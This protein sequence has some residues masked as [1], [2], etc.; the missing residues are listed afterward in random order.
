MTQWVMSEAL[1]AELLAQLDGAARAAGV[2]SGGRTAGTPIGVG[3]LEWTDP[4]RQ[5]RAESALQADTARGVRWMEHASGGAG[6]QA[7]PVQD[8][9]AASAYGWPADAAAAADGESGMEAVSRFFER[10]ARRYG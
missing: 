8:A 7:A 3:W 10:D 6:V 5:H 2:W 9:A 4:A 1:A